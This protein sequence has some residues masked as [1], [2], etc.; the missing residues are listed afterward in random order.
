MVPPGHPVPHRTHEEDRALLAPASRTDPELFPGSKAAFQRRRRRSEQQSQSHYEEILRVSHLP[1]SRTR[2]LSL[3]WQAARA[4]IYPRFFLTNRV[5]YDRHTR[6][7]PST[8]ASEVVV[9]F[10]LFS[11]LTGQD[12]RSRLYRRRDAVVRKLLI[13]LPLFLTTAIGWACGDKLMLVMRVRLA[14]LKLGHPIT[15]LGYTQRDL[16]SSASVRQIRLQPDVKKAGHRFQF[17]EDS[18]KLDD[19]LKAEKYDIVVADVA[20][21]DQLSQRVQASPSHPV[22]LPV[23]YKGTKAEDS[24]TKKK[25]HCLLKAPGGADQ[26]FDAIDQALQWKA[27]TVAR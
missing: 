12:P 2:P 18:A 27:K 23:S 25:Y 7:I 5:I 13:F 22:I 19:A 24:A 16:P 4:R 14:Q 9:F 17:V 3:T 20:V 15:I 6:L 1:N 11:F 8:A 10:L 26:Y 21:A